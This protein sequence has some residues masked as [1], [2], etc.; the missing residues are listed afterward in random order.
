MRRTQLYLPDRIH[1]ELA[2]K[3]SEEKRTISDLTRQ[4]LEEGLKIKKT[5]KT[6]NSASFLL[7]LAEKAERRGWSGPK[8]LSNKTDKYLYEK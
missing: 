5:K 8:D 3:A 1:Q 6:V 2:R 7:K 4:L